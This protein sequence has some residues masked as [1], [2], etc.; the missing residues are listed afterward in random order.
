M[1]LQK[2]VRVVSEGFKKHTENF[3]IDGKVDG[4]KVLQH[5]GGFEF[6]TLS[7]Q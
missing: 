5:L 3:T 7:V 2:K 1:P 4:L 6:I